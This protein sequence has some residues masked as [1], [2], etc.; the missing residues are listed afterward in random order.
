[1]LSQ[2][3]VCHQDI[4]SNV[5]P[6]HVMAVPAPLARSSEQLDSITANMYMAKRVCAMPSQKNVKR[7]LPSAEK[8]EAQLML[9]NPRDAFIVYVENVVTLKSGSQVTQGH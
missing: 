4:A 7:S 6:Q 9:T 1:M 8:Q 2:Y 3:Y 5:G